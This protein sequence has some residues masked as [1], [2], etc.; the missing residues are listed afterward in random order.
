MIL[1]IL[2]RLAA[3]SGRN[4]KEEI[5][6]AVKG[7][8]HEDLFKRVIHLAYDPSY[9]FWV[10]EFHQFASTQGDIALSH[11]LDELEGKIATREVS[12]HAAIA[13]VETLYRE[14]GKD[15]AEV[16]DRI[17]NRDL[18][19]GVGAKTFNKVWP[20]LIYI[21]PYM[22]C[23]SFSKKNL[24]KVTFPCYSQLKMDGL[25]VDVMVHEGKVTYMSRN[26]KVLNFHHP[27][28]D[29][30][31]DSLPNGVYMGEAVALNEDCQTLM[32]R[33]KSNGYLNSD[34]IDPARLMFYLWDTVPTSDFTTKKCTVPY[35]TRF[36]KLGTIV[37][38]VDTNRISIVDSRLCENAEDVKAHAIECVSRGEEGTVIKD[39]SMIW[40]DG[41]NPLQ[42]KIKPDFEV[43]LKV[44]DYKMGKGRNENVLGALVCR[45]S[46]DLL[47]VSVGTGYS[48]KLREQLLREVEGMVS[49]NDVVTVKANDIITNDSKPDMY[50]LFLPRFIKVRK[51]KTEADSFARVQEQKNSY[52]DALDM[53]G[54]E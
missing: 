46:D 54:S 24:A 31:F 49:R 13:F 29:A 40:R 51:D 26:G 22:R 18:R 52:E 25:Y 5:L 39:Q 9:N 20:D 11:A 12:G 37:R 48:D 27:E 41:D 1:S 21:H 45:T 43:D 23:K 7:E 32:D 30:A 28:T 3:T 17:I 34:E 44:V 50:S 42:V 36:L 10:R 15:D 6:Q 35:S 4:D 16:L 53:I 19:C 47:E 38:M 14:L 2:D 33:S 8:P